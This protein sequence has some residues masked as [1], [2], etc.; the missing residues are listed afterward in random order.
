MV[1]EAGWKA[2][3]LFKK[4]E[5]AFFFYLQSLLNTWELSQCFTLAEK[6]HQNL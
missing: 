1:C 5:L 3:D 6:L 2:L 4:L